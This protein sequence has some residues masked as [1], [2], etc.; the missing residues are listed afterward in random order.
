MESSTNDARRDEAGGL[1]DRAQE[2]AGQVA[3]R[4]QDVAGTVAER[5]RYQARR[6]ED[7]FYENPLAIGAATLALGLAAGLAVPTTRREVELMGDTRDR[8]VDQVREV[9][10]ETKEKVQHVAERVMGEAQTTAKEA[11]REKGLTSG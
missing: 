2:A 9:T 6:V 11:A 3:T 8:L 5:T 10:Q 4:A 7:R 1:A